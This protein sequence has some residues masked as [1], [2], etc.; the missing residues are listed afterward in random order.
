MSLNDLDSILNKEAI[1]ATYPAAHLRSNP[2]Q[3]EQMY[4]AHAMT[5]IPLGDTSR[6]VDT[7]F[8]WVGGQ[9]KGA[10]IGAVIGDYGHGKTSFQVHVWE[11]STE[12]KVFLF[13]CFLCLV[14]F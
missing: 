1:I 5:H 13:I 8:K 4:R 2:E 14:S 6:Y 3:V 7:I 10:F 9:N 11:E 12:R